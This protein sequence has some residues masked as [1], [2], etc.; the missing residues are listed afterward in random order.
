MLRIDH[1]TFCAPKLEPLRDAFAATGLATEYGGAHANGV[2]HMALLGFAD[3]SYIEL[4]APMRPQT[5]SPLWDRAIRAAAGP[6]A[7][8]VR[9][10]DIAADVQQLRARG[11]PV[12]GPEPLGRRRPDGVLAEWELA[13]PGAQ[14]PGA[15]LPFLIQ[16]RTPRAHRVRPSASVVGS[17]VTGVARVVLGVREMDSAIRLFRQAYGWASPEKADDSV[18][19]AH[20]SHFPDTPVVL[21]APLGPDGWLA[22]RLQ[23]VGEAPVAFLIQ[24]EATETILG[25]DLFPAAEPWF[26]REVGWFDPERLGGKRLGV[27][28]TAT[29]PA[30]TSP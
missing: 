10:D 14:E 3:G 20:L 26:G 24:S 7:W 11:I 2:T 6:C 18:F 4:I 27:I 15:L 30:S 13:F 12:R 16:D 17:G 29:D 1:V 25:Q 21:A 22:E 8:A 28:T 19:G 5:E 23:R 9:S